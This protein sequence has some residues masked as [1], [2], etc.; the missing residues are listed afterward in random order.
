MRSGNTG[1]DPYIVLTVTPIRGKPG[2]IL[3][4]VRL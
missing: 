2:L 4:H 1:E 3:L